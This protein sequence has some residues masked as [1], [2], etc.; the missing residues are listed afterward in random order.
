M[1]GF[2]S[3]RL[4]DQGLI[5]GSLDL[6]P[7]SSTTGQA[8]NVTADSITVLRDDR[9]HVVT[10][11]IPIVDIAKIRKANLKRGMSVATKIALGVAVGLGV[12]VVAGLAACAAAADAPKDVVEATR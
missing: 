2:P 6:A 4:T 9:G 8:F 7:P 12:L 1:R 3:D 5:L 11:T 10:E